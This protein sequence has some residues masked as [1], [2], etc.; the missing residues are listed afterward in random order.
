MEVRQAFGIVLKKNRINK[1]MTQEQLAFNSDL[2]RTY[3]GLLE[4]SKRQ[5]TIETIFKISQVLEIKPHELIKEIE[6]L[7]MES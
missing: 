4:R 5:P 1:N 7:C 3:I 2:D 6:E